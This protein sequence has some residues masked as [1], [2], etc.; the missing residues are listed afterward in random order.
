MKKSELTILFEQAEATINTRRNNLHLLGSLNALAQL[1]ADER[2]LMI[3]KQFQNSSVFQEKRDIDD[4]SFLA[5]L[6]SAE[7]NNL[8]LTLEKGDMISRICRHWLRY[9]LGDQ[10]TFIGTKISDIAFK[11]LMYLDNV[12]FDINEIYAFMRSQKD[13]GKKVFQNPTSVNRDSFSQAAIEILTNH[14]VTRDFL[15]ECALEDSSQPQLLASLPERFFELLQEYLMALHAIGK[16]NSF[17]SFPSDTS[18]DECDQ[19]RK[20]FFEKIDAEISSENRT[21]LSKIK[22]HAPLNVGGTE[23]VAYNRIVEGQPGYE[24][25]ISQQIYLWAFLRERKANIVVPMEISNHFQANRYNLG[26]TGPQQNGL[27]IPIINTLPSLESVLASFREVEERNTAIMLLRLLADIDITPSMMATQPETFSLR[28]QGNNS[29][30][31]III[32]GD[33]SNASRRTQTQQTTP[34][35]SEIMSLAAMMSLLS[36]QNEINR[37]SSNSLFSQLRTDQPI[38]SGFGSL[39]RNS[40][41]RLLF[42]TLSPSHSSSLTPTSPP[43]NLSNS[44]NGNN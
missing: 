12:Y 8:A 33:G 31:D 6:Q 34:G 1:E 30:L 11:D 20:C 16:K 38:G 15:L 19:A 43:T 42:P 27:S 36:A 29:P 3:I 24:C 25:V 35:I 2:A 23:D 41:A 7:W 26:N 13:E 5:L 10:A 14:A 37:G 17:W 40:T 21:I 39:V 28:T 22:I 18:I 32:L 9:D 4:I 44:R